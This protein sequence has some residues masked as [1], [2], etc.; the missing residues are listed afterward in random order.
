MQSLIVKTAMRLVTRDWVV[1]RPVVAA[2]I[3]DLNNHPTAKRSL[4]AFLIIA[5]DRRHGQHPGFDVVAIFRAMWRRVTTSKREGAST[6]AQQFVRTLTNR[7]ERTIRRKVKEILLSVLV[8]ATFNS[9]DIARAY[10]KVA[11][12]G[13]RMNGLRQACLNLGIDPSNINDFEA[14]GLIARLKYPQP[15]HMPSKRRMQIRQRT[16]Y[17]LNQ[18]KRDIPCG[19]LDLFSTS[20]R[21]ES[22]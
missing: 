22:F 11:Y 6:I 10:L 4:I 3:A 5:E 15:Q 8:T 17:V 20:L 13:W 2:H 12:Y 19:D 1:L 21:N 7:R 9:D 14:A 18:S 16:A